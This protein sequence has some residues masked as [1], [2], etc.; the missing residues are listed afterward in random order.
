MDYMQAFWN[1]HY[2]DHPV[3][4]RDLARIRHATP[5]HPSAQGLKTNMLMDSMEITNTSILSYDDLEA[6]IMDFQIFGDYG[7][8]RVG[9]KRSGRATRLQP[10]QSMRMVRLKHPEDYAM[11]KPRSFPGFMLDD[12]EFL[13]KFPRG[14]VTFSRQHCPVQE[15]YGV[16]AWLAAVN[17]MLLKESATLFRRKYYLNNAHMGYI[18]Y[19]T[20]PRASNTS[21]KKIESALDDGKG[22]NNFKSL[23]IHE[24]NGDP[25]GIKVI[26]VSE[27]AAKDE[28]LNVNE[29]SQADML[30]IERVPAGLLGQVPK[31]A[32]GFGSITDAYKIFFK[33][34][35]KPKW[36]KFQAINTAAGFELIKFHELDLGDLQSSA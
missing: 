5:H 19:T 21:I 7:I 35:I 23:L 31:N 15:I 16:P 14:T 27:F 1:G 26:P 22:I 18:L 20:L 10:L 13:K 8:A 30:T 28:F 6:L 25:D 12:P 17:S 3:S 4:R 33:A 2:Y 9:E 29:I 24:S 11:V 32:A 36:R 34:E